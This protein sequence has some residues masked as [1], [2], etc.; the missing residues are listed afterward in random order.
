[1]IGQRAAHSQHGAAHSLLALRR[2]SDGRESPL[3]SYRDFA[4]FGGDR[5]WPSRGFHRDQELIVTQLACLHEMG[6]ISLTGDLLVVGEFCGNADYTALLLPFLRSLP[7]TRK[8]DLVLTEYSADLLR[9]AAH[10]SSFFT[11]PGKVIASIHDPYSSA[12]EALIKPFPDRRRLLLPFRLGL[13]ERPAR[14]EHLL[15]SRSSLLRPGDIA[16][17]CFLKKD[18]KSQEVLQTWVQTPATIA[19]IGGVSHGRQSV[20]ESIQAPLGHEG[21]SD[22]DSTSLH[23]CAFEEWAVERI[24]Q[25]SGA[26]KVTAMDEVAV[27]FD[28]ERTIN[29]ITAIWQRSKQAPNERQ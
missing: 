24:I 17:A 3:R 6:S 2:M 5:G 11:R 18:Q 28:E 14:L 19:G 20:P 15:R 21:I 13:L 10:F 23:L 12:P 7:A 29:M 27:S 25:A 8:I 9:L 16:A 26:V 4:L 1:M 22:E